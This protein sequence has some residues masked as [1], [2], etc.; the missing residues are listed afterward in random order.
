MSRRDSNRGRGKFRP[1]QP[2]QPGNGNSS[3]AEN[4]NSS[5]SKHANSSGH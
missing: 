5:Q 2:A 4:N 1:A 3:S